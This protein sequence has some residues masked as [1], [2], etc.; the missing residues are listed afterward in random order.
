VAARIG[1]ILHL[2]NVVILLV[3]LVFRAEVA[4]QQGAYAASVLV[5]LTAASVAAYLDVRA[6][7]AG[8]RWRW[9]A[10]VPFAV[11]ATSFS[12]WPC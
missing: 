12:V 7:W 10:L 3:T 4:S 9:L 8:S 1:V 2:F 11:I 6:R 5:L